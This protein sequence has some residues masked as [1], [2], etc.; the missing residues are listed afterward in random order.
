MYCL[1]V[2]Q[3]LLYYLSNT[4]ILID[5]ILF[6]VCLKRSEGLRSNWR[7]WA[8]MV[9]SK[10]SCENIDSV[11]WEMHMHWSSGTCT[12]F[13]IL[14]GSFGHKIMTWK[15][16]MNRR[17]LFTHKPWFYRFLRENAWWIYIATKRISSI[18][19]CLYNK[20]HTVRKKKRVKHC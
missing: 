9:W 10:F 15:Q 13:Q 17:L 3:F 2:L 7:G 20:R 11:Q 18:C 19:K 14:N 5:I 6:Y 8:F 4:E 16:I 1:N 12:M